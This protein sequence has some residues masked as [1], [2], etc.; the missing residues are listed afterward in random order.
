MLHQVRT[1]TKFLL[2]HRRRYTTMFALWDM[3]VAVWG[4]CGCEVLVAV[5]GAG[6]SVGCW[7]LCRVLVAVWGVGGCVGC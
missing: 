2:R 1:A 5:W 3:L 4:A 7:W 6:G